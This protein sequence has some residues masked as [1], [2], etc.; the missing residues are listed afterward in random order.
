MIV[1]EHENFIIIK[2][3]LGEIGEDVQKGFDEE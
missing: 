2:K 3:I 1:L